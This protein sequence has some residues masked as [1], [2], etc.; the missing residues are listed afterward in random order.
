M[1]PCLF[2]LLLF[3]TRTSTQ[4]S[5][6]PICL[7]YGRSH[8]ICHVRRPSRPEN[9]RVPTA[10]PRPAGQQTPSEEKWNITHIDREVWVV[11]H[12]GYDLSLAQ[13]D[14]QMPRD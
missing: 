12:K 1:T 10:N 2:V 9:A 13:L 5:I 8:E 4:W 3:G 14:P 6:L 11:V 7:Y